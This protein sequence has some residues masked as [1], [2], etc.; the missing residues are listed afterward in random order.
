[1]SVCDPARRIARPTR[2]ARQCRGSGPTDVPVD[3]AHP[4][5]DLEMRSLPGEMR[6]D[7]LLAAGAIFFVGEVQPFPSVVTLSLG[8]TPIISFQ[9]LSSTACRPA[10][11]SPRGRRS[12]RRLQGIALFRLAGGLERGK[13]VAVQPDHFFLVALFGLESI[14]VHPVGAE[15][16]VD[17]RAARGNSHHCCVC[18]RLA[19]ATAAPAP[20]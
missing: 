1:M 11:P 7:R 2:H 15:R 17:R 18:Q 20:T 6:L 12:S 3:V 16:Q 19:L 13:R 4:I 9:R 8:D 5:L 14:D 10:R